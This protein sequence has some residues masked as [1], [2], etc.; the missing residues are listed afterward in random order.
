MTSPDWTEQ[1][2]HYVAWFWKSEARRE[3]AKFGRGVTV[4]AIRS[5][6]TLK[7]LAPPH[8]ERAWGTVTRKA[9]ASGL[10]VPTGGYAPARSSHNSPKRLYRSGRT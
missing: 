3:A 9:I 7:G 5:W 10:L 4:E 6:A 1:A 2:L 8:D